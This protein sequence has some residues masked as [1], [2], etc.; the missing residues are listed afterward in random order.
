MCSKTLC[1]NKLSLLI[2]GCIILCTKVYSSLIFT[3]SL[4]LY[5]KPNSLILCMY[6]C[7]IGGETKWCVVSGLH[8]VPDDIRP[9]PLRASQEA[10]EDP[11]NHWSQTRDILPRCRT[12]C[13]SWHHEGMYATVVLCYRYR[14][15]DWLY[16]INVKNQ[17]F[18]NVPEWYMYIWHIRFLGEL[19]RIN[20]DIDSSH[21]WNLSSIVDFEHCSVIWVP[22]S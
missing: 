2:F 8:S 18:P 17:F 22:S 1:S 16:K 7:I 11:G 5:Y 13:C 20:E 19:F 4:V 6:V 9:H 15:S 21:V 10:T 3:N 14:H 12:P